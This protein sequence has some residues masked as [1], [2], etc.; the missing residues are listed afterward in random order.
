MRFIKEEPRVVQGRERAVSDTKERVPTVAR[1]GIV[2]QTAGRSSGVWTVEDIKSFET[3]GSTWSRKERCALMII[4]G[5]KEILRGVPNGWL[6]HQE[7][8]MLRLIELSAT[9]RRPGPRP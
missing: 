4:R 5:G 6:C 7:L 8:A 1:L 9:L 3:H 2:Q